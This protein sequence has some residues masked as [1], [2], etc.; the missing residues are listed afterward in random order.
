MDIPV[1]I[2][3]CD[4]KYLHTQKYTVYFPTPPHLLN[5]TMNEPNSAT[6]N[7]AVTAG[8][9]AN[10][11]ETNTLL[12]MTF[13][14]LLVAGLWAIDIDLPLLYLRYSGFVYRWCHVF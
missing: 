4:G 8:S 11:S 14:G 7:S 6:N 9:D 12:M 1:V 2:F 10:R 5:N 13:I 3:G